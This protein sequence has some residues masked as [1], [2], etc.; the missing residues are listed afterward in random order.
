MAKLTF[1]IYLAKEDVE[2]FDDLLTE[3]AREKFG[4]PGFFVQELPDFADGGKLY[5]VSNRE[6]IP[7]WYK[8][9]ANHFELDFQTATKSSSAV[10]I[11]RSERRIFACPFAFG[12]MYLNDRK[13]EADFG[14]RA[15][16][17]ALDDKRLQKIER[18]NLSDAIRG[19]E[20]SPFKRDLNSFG[21]EAA[22][23]LVRRVG[24]D[25]QDDS[26]ADTMSGAQSLKLTGDFDLDA[27][28]DLAKDALE[29]FSSD[30]YKTTSFVAL[31]VIRPIRD[32]AVVER[33]DDLV[34]QRIKGDH[35]DFEFGLPVTLSDESIMYSF[36]GPRLLGGFPNLNLSDYI[37]ALG[38]RANELTVDTLKKHKVIASFQEDDRPD[39]TWS[40]RQ[41]LVGTLVNE[42]GLY[43]L[44]EGEWYRIDQ[45]F[46]DNVIRA[47]EE[48]VQDWGPHR[49][50]RPLKKIYD[51][52][53]DGVYE[54]EGD[55]N[56]AIGQDLGYLVFDTVMI[57]V[58]DVPNSGF[59]ACDLLDLDGKRLIHV[60]KSSR[61]SSVLSHFFKQGAN[62]ARNIKCFPPV[63][64]Q[65]VNY[66]AEAYSQ[67][68]ADQL[69]DSFFEGNLNDWTVEYWIADRPRADGNF[70][71]PF[72]SKASFSEERRSMLS[73]SYQVVMRFIELR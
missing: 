12:W 73:M 44:N 56:A 45:T 70:N 61:R 46:R 22:L 52:K 3:T 43:A 31:D 40:V 10:L 21:L 1:T 34:L 20:L 38:D 2:D 57:K 54:A 68:Q 59:E 29:L 16:I 69:Q 35:G 28:P 14:L 27:L 9:L 51:D 7:S 39:R 24:G 72:F 30:F 41:S 4:L 60:K 71:I 55:Y 13:L 67:A 47:F 23:N 53:D 65:M 49:S 6:Q 19:I 66:V 25:A 48:A 11:F 8:R 64:E 32:K 18:A 5:V 33:L 17:N 50:P 15:A 36:Q 37:E 26:S 62:S 58:P 42:D 63:R